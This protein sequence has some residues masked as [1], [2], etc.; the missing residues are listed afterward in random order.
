MEENYEKILWEGY[1]LHFLGGNRIRTGYLCKTDKQMVEIR[2]VNTQKNHILFEYAL[3][4]HLIKKDFCHISTFLI[5]K[6]NLPYYMVEKDCYVAERPLEA[7]PLAEEEKQTFILGAKTLSMLLFANA[8]HTS[9]LL[10]P[11]ISP[12]IIQIIFGSSL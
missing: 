4:Q 11:R 6:E 8:S 10:S 2:K 1:G 3:K 7:Q 9:V 12:P 5:T